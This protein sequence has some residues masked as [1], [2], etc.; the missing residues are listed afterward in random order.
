MAGAQPR[1]WRIDRSR[2][3]TKRRQPAPMQCL[4]RASFRQRIHLKRGQCRRAARERPAM[5]LP[6]LVSARCRTSVLRPGLILRRSQRSGQYQISHVPKPG[7]RLS[8]PSVQ[9]LSRRNGR[10]LSLNR[11]RVQYRSLSN[12]PHRSH[13]R[14]SV[15]L[16]SLSN[17][18]LPS[19]NPPRGQ[20]R[21]SR[22]LKLGPH[23]SRHRS[24]SNALRRRQRSVQLRSLSNGPP[25]SQRSVQLRS[26]NNDPRRRLAPSNDP[27]RNRRKRRPTSPTNRPAIDA[28]SGHVR[29]RRGCC[30]AG[31][32]HLLQSVRQ[33]CRLT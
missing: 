10:L 18:P 28:V 7:P 21:S 5:R 15:Q 24:L 19:P 32:C 23:P 16:L 33:S 12:G 2:P 4:E 27:L 13:S 1:W 25:L 11:R 29:T 3:P 6:S 9:L 31:A 20:R 8:Q 14:L 30:N 17:A 22:A 26:L